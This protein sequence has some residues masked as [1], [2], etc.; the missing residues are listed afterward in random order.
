M[1]DF[2]NPELTWNVDDLF[3]FDAASIDPVYADGHIIPHQHM[4]DGQD[5]DLNN[6]EVYDQSESALVPTAGA[7]DTRNHLQPA[8]Y[9]VPRELHNDF[10]GVEEPSTPRSSQ[11]FDSSSIQL[12]NCLDDSCFLDSPISP[13]IA[14]GDFSTFAHSPSEKSTGVSGELTNQATESANQSEYVFFLGLR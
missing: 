8:C 1:S 6:N 11:N 4:E 12:A 3:D 9:V 14:S 7:L 5:E 2:I 13:F 10:S